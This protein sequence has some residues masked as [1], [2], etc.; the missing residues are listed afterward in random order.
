MF[1][2]KAI[3][4]VCAG[5][6][7]NGMVAFRHEKYIEKGGPSGGDGGRG[8]SVYFVGS[9][10][11]NTLLEFKYRKKI[12]APNGEN[13]KGKQCYGKKGE[14]IYV[15]VPLGTIIYDEI[16]N[17]VIADIN[18]NNQQVLIAKGGRGGRGNCHFA[19]S[20]Y[21]AP[22]IAENGEPGEKLKIRLELKLLADVGLVGFPSVGKSTLLSV[23]SAARP[24]IASYHFTTLSPNLGVVQ[25]Q[26][27]SFVMADLPGLIEGASQGKGLGFQF[28]RHIERCRV[29]LHVIDMAA[30]DG[31][32]PYQDYLTIKEELKQYNP[33]LLKRPQ[34]ILANKMDQEEASLFLEEFKEKLQDDIPIYPISAIT[35]Q[36]IQPV[37]Q[38]IFEIL[39]KTPLFPLFIDK[40][41]YKVYE[42]HEEEFCQVKKEKGIYI[43]YGKPVENLYQRSN[44]STDAGVLKFIRIL[45]YN[46][47]EEK[48]K[49]AGIQDGDTVK[50][51]EYEFEYFE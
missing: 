32:D 40:E 24:E 48:L 15:K 16:N 29:L 34:L 26:D 5:N 35:H 42:Y 46:G 2:D 50:V 20:R 10:S 23:V 51:V 33:E 18:E 47:V 28:L 44:L 43:V 14:D 41:E 17:Y 19:N 27:K 31:R 8:G 21:Q 6:G 12:V 4:D 37:I 30:T 11:I 9:S 49:E 45:R 3:L 1:I 25:L 22:E 36:N 7:G 39:D 13:G 38:K